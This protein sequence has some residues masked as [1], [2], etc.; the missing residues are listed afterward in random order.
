MN[1]GKTF[2]DQLISVLSYHEFNKSVDRF[3]GNYQV[4][5]FDRR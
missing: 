5:I 1:Q 2:F 3:K 4:R